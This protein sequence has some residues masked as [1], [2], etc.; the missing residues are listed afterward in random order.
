MK[1]QLWITITLVNLFFV[2]TLRS[3][4]KLDYAISRHIFE[5]SIVT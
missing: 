1:L 4:L 5:L 3:F 2:G